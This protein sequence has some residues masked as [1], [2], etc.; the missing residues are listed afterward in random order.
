MEQQ[1]HSKRTHARTHSVT[2]FSNKLC[3]AGNLFNSP[4]LAALVGLQHD[5]GNLTGSC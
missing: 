4:L 1:Q 2:T 3:V 5:D